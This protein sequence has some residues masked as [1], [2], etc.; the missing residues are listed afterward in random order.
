M[1]GEVYVG[2]WWALL[3]TVGLLVHLFQLLL[4]LL[5]V[6]VVMGVACRGIHLWLEG[7]STILSGTVGR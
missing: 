2:Q 6:V 5:L 4:L 1:Q 7:S 3:L